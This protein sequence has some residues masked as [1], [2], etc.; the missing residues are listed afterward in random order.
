MEIR[1]TYPD[2]DMDPDTDPD[3]DTYRE[4]GKMG[5]GGGMHSPSASSCICSNTGDAYYLQCFDTVGW[6]S[7][8]APGL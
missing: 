8:R 6:A 3:P 4:T 7:A 1:I 5:L 2:P